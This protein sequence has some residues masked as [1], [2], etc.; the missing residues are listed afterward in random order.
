MTLYIHCFC[1]TRRAKRS[2]P[3]GFKGNDW[4]RRL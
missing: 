2:D 4:F 1:S 3:N